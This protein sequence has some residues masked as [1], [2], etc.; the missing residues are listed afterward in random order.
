MANTKGKNETWVQMVR[1][2]SVVA[3]VVLFV[4]VAV[5][6]NWNYQT[7]DQTDAGK[8]LGDAALVGGETGDPL[9]GRGG[10]IFANVLLYIAVALTVVSGADYLIRNRDCIKDM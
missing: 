3:A 10:V 8:T 5:Y 7:G 6:L 2:N 9:L 4:C 1:R